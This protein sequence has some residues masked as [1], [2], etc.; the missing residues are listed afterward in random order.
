MKTIWGSKLLLTFIAAIL[1][2]T[3][4][5]DQSDKAWNETLNKAKGQTVYFNAWGGSDQINAYIDWA[6]DEVN[7]RYG[8]RLQ[9][10]KVSDTADV[11]SRVLAEKQA[12]REDKGT[13]DLVWINGENFKSMKKNALLYGPFTNELPSFEGIDTVEKPTT[14]LDFGEPVDGL[15][16]PWGMA[17]L[18]FIY[19]SE[20]LDSTPASALELLEFSRKN[21]GRVTYPMPPDF[22]GT[23]FLK[24]ALLELSESPNALIKPVGQVDFEKVTAPLWRYLDQLHPVLWREGNSFPQNNLALTPML[25]DGEIVLSMSFNPSYASSAIA[26]GELPDSVRT[27]VHKQG[28]LGNTHFL[29]IPFNSNASEGAR[30]IINFLLSP[31]AQARKVNPEIW[32]DPTILS[33]SR[34]STA[35]R[36]RFENVPL[37][38]ATLS[39]DALGKVLPEPHSSWVSALEQAWQKRYR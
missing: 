8:V 31:E 1:A 17:Q 3:V 28:S 37:G 26:S 6:A 18:V 14:L 23:T 13:V 35:D 27:Y 29:A 30:V 15:E 11:V 7:K 19:D 12:G 22:I 33:M 25:D 2:F 20:R 24:Q 5:A 10:V 9:H 21:P 36:K 38:V 4:Q 39:P 16:A 34:L 32:G